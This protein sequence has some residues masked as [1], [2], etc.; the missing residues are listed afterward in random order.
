MDLQDGKTRFK[1]T[2]SIQM[3]I[4]SIP[5][6]NHAILLTAMSPVLAT[7]SAEHVLFVYSSN[8]VKC[9]TVRTGLLY[10]DD[11]GVVNEDGEEE[12]HTY[13]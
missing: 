2:M 4:R 8:C 6:D 11:D 13:L 9:D 5:G 1:S 7:N 12:D 10:Y 3:M